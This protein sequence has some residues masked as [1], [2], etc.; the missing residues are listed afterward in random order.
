MLRTFKIGSVLV[1][2]TAALGLG[3]AAPASADGVGAQA[4]IANAYEDPNFQG[5]EQPIAVLDNNCHNTDALNNAIS[6]QSARNRDQSTQTIRFFVTNNC[7][8]D[9]EFVDV[10]P[11]ESDSDFDFL[12]DAPAL[13]YR[14]VV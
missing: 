13:S 1:A 14:A 11:S 5:N 8:P 12:M 2:C 3:L 4:V 9:D 6:A 7:D 10:E